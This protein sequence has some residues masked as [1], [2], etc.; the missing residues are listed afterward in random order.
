MIFFSDGGLDIDALK[1]VAQ[2]IEKLRLSGGS[3][4][5]ITHYSRI[6]NEV[7]PDKIHIFGDGTILKE[8]DFSLAKIL[9]DNGYDFVLSNMDNRPS[10]EENIF[11]GS[12]GI[13]HS[14]HLR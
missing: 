14:F 2:Q 4:L 11:G 13:L 1:D 8:G 7:H 5:L 12:K 9:E 3:A 6:L 10:E